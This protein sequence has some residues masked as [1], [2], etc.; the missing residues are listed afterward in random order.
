MAWLQASSGGSDRPQIAD[1]ESNATVK[2]F[3]SLAVSAIYWVIHTNISHFHTKE[4]GIYRFSKEFRGR[5]SRHSTSVPSRLCKAKAELLAGA[6]G[7]APARCGVRFRV[8]AMQS[9]RAC[10]VRLGL[11]ASSRTERRPQGINHCRC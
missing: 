2:I 3:E 8:P 5:N 11:V 9:F 6:A 10:D 1:S 4:S 7:A